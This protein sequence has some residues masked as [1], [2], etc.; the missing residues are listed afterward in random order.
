MDKMEK[1]LDSLVEK[2]KAEGLSE[3]E[4][5]MK[6]FNSPEVTEAV[7]PGLNQNRKEPHDE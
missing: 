2:Y 1:L 4:A 7:Y 3:F 6:A 5:R